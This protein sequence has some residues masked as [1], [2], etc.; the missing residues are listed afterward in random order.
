MPSDGSGLEQIERKIPHLQYFMELF[1]EREDAY[2][3]P[4][5]RKARFERVKTIL[6]S[7]WQDIQTYAMQMANNAEFRRMM[8]ALTSAVKTVQTVLKNI[9]MAPKMRQHSLL[10]LNWDVGEGVM[11]KPN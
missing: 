9:E 2:Y 4:D 5:G 6:M 1:T 11:L 8:D 3:W 7:C 10:L